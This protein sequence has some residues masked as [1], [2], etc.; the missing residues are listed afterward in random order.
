MIK[1]KQLGRLVMAAVTAMSIWG[2]SDFAEA[3]DAGMHVDQVGYLSGYSKAAMVTDSGE[4]EFY[5]VDVKTGQTVYQGQL[6]APKYDA[7][8]EETL[9]RADFSDFKAAGTYVLKVGGRT[10]PEFAIGDNVYAVPAVQ[11]LRSYTLSR[12]GSPIDDDITGLKKVSITWSFRDPFSVVNEARSA[13]PP[14]P[15]G[16]VAEVHVR[17]EIQDDLL[18]DGRCFFVKDDL[19]LLLRYA[20]DGKGSSE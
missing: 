15:F 4:G 8:S 19:Q 5:L 7:M 12:C 11:T 10:S 16:T 6:S 2:A 13:A 9:R 1:N 3:A 20:V 18:F 14:H 17:E